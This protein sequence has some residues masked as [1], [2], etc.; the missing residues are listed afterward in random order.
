MSGYLNDVVRLYLDE[1]I[2]WDTY[3]AWRR[4]E[5]GDLAAERGALAEILETAAQICAGMEAD[6]RA[7]WDQAASLVDGQVEDRSR[8]AVA[9]AA[10]ANPL[11]LAYK[12]GWDNFEAIVAKPTE[13]SAIRIGNPVSIRRAIL[14]LERYEGVVEQA[15]EAELAE[16]AA[17]ADRTGTFCCPHTGV[18]LAVLDKLIARGDIQKG[19]RVVVISTASGLKFA[20]FKIR[21]HEKAIEGGRQPTGQPAHFPAER[22]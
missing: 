21:Y 12:K 3:Y 20:D 1:L 8:I 6:T 7:G 10:A 9:Q 15:S 5:S 22:I 13:A 17:A 11:Y 4:G 14:T 18:A 16:A 2:D 19:Q